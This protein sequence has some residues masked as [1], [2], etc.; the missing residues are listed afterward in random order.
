MN[1]TTLYVC[2]VDFVYIY[3]TILEDQKPRVSASIINV[4]PRNITYNAP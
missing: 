3:T 4:F 1:Q 2:H